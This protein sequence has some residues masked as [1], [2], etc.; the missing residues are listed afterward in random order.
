MILDRKNCVLCKQSLVSFLFRTSGW[1]GIWVGLIWGFRLDIP[2]WLPPI[3]SRSGYLYRVFRNH[4]LKNQH[5]LIFPHQD[6]YGYLITALTFAGHIS[7]FCTLFHPFPQVLTRLYGHFD[8]WGLPTIWN[9]SIRITTSLTSI[10]NNTTEPL[11]WQAL[12]P[13][14]CNL[15]PF[16]TPSQAG[17]SSLDA[18][19]RVPQRHL[20][21]HSTIDEEE[22]SVHI[23]R[24]ERGENV[25]QIGLERSGVLL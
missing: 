7:T 24:F 21:M 4:L 2:G 17:M 13:S 15:L 11:I 1:I 3:L 14:F 12:F 16:Q 19:T 23:M 20:W 9:A 8:P 6:P 10:V 22:E 25:I 18:S 5:F